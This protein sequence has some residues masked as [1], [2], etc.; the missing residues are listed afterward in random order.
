M[1]GFRLSCQLRIY[2]QRRKEEKKE[3]HEGRRGVDTKDEVMTQSAVM[4]LRECA[5]TTEREFFHSSIKM[6]DYS[7]NDLLDLRTQ[8]AVS[9]EL[10]STCVYT[11]HPSVSIL[12]VHWLIIFEGPVHDTGAFPDERTGAASQSDKNVRVNQAVNLKQEGDFHWGLITWIY[13]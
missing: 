3:Q 12:I 4:F 9:T 10:R 1:F 8:E 6:L 7:R 11:S 5:D 2:N 13:L